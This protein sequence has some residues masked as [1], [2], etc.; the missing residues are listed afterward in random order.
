MRHQNKKGRIS[1]SISHRKATLKSMANSLFLY[2]RIETTAAKAKAL[3][4]FAEPLIT[5]AKK[6]IT[7]IAARRLAFKKLCD[8]SIVKILF[9]DLAPLYKDI[10]GGYTRIMPCGN[11]KGDGAQ[12]VIMELTKRTISDEDLL[13][14]P[15]A[16]KE[17]APSEVKKKAKAS[18]TLSG[19]KKTVKKATEKVSEENKK[20]KRTHSVARDISVGEK[21]EHFVED[22]KKEKA[23]TEQK[24]IGKKGIFR[25]FR[26]K[27]I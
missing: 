8:K 27:S 7:S 13:G 10:P 21:E 12:V 18:D 3:R 6:D 26:R 4:S 20:S 19:K 25:Y 1:R 5:L 9:N 16:K 22:V 11:R 23:R 2:Q 15:G 24:K 17:A 14:A